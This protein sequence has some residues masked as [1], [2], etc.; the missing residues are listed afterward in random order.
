MI[1]SRSDP[2]PVVM[3]WITVCIHLGS[4]GK[5]SL[6]QCLF[7]EKG[8]SV[9]F[10]Q[11]AV[12]HVNIDIT[13]FRVSKRTR[14]SADDFETE[15]LPK[16]NCRFV[17]RDN[18]IKLHRAET[19]PARFAYTMFTHRATNSQTTRLRCNH[20]RRVRNVRPAARLVGPQNIS[21]YDILTLNNCRR[22]R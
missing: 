18:E 10:K 15:L 3:T 2:R 7:G 14:Q 1:F 6:L 16:T 4:T 20:E 13:L 11:R 17:C 21:A 9:V 19:E 12:H 22:S 8:L 5:S